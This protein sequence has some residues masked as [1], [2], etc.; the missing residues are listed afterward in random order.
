MPAPE[1]GLDDHLSALNETSMTLASGRRGKGGMRWCQLARRPDE[2]D[3]WSG[4]ARSQGYR[5]EEEDGKREPSNKPPQARLR[6]CE[7]AEEEEDEQVEKR[8]VSLY[9]RPTRRPDQVIDTVCQAASAAS[10]PGESEWQLMPGLTGLWQ[11]HGRSNIPFEG[12]V[13]LDYLYVTNW[14]MWVDLKLL[15]RTG[16]VVA[17]GHGAD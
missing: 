4:K 15:I 1:H 7:G 6:A 9:Q 13:D 3:S 2:A 11:V 5:A 10:T 16:G 14:S 8:S 17:R 12:M